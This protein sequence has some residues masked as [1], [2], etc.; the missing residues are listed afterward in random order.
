MLKTDPG[1]ENKIL[2]I[3]YLQ[4]ETPRIKGLNELKGNYQTYF[5]SLKTNLSINYG[6]QPSQKKKQKVKQKEV[7]PY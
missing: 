2:E 6:C 1:L 7:Y 5:Q 3:K 4:R